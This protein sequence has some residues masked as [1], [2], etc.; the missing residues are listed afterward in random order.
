MS[1]W[2]DE[3]ERRVKHL[4]QKVEKLEAQVELARRVAEM[5]S[6]ADPSDELYCALIASIQHLRKRFDDA[7]KYKLIANSAAKL[8]EDLR[9]HQPELWRLLDQEAL[10]GNIQQHLTSLMSQLASIKLTN[11]PENE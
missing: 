6:I 8:L 4:E 10:R 5:R 1:N 2:R 9:K 3:E 11:D 7:I